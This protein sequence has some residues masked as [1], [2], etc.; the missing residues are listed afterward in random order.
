M[1]RRINQH[2]LITDCSCT[3][4]FALAFRAV[5]RPQVQRVE[6]QLTS[7]DSSTGPSHEYF[8][9]LVLIVLN[10]LS[11]SPCFVS[12]AAT[13]RK[14]HVG[15]YGHSRPAHGALWACLQR[16]ASAAIFKNAIFKPSHHMTNKQSSRQQTLPLKRTPKS[17]TTQLRP[18]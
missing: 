3:W 7:Y 5:H 17:Q 11:C 6:D 8:Y 2:V 10:G 12:R 1:T 16:Q 4:V 13:S 14:H 9:F 18:G 15:Q